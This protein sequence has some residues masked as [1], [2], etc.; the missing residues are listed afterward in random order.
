MGGTFSPAHSRLISVFG[1][2]P[3]WDLSVV[4]TRPCGPDTL[5]GAICQQPS[6]LPNRSSDNIRG[7]R[8]ALQACARHLFG[9]I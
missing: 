3:S 5:S 4:E 2:R 7:K 6:T 1:N 9:S 8:L